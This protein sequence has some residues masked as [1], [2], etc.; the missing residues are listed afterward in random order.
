LNGVRQSSHCTK[1]C[2]DSYSDV[3][4]A[5]GENGQENLRTIFTHISFYLVGEMGKSEMEYGQ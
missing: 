5:K 3:A 2:Y 4:V 1:F